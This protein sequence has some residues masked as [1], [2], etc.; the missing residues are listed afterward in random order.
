MKYEI[1]KSGKIGRELRSIA[2]DVIGRARDELDRGH[3]NGAAAIH[4]HRARTQFKKTRGVLRLA[5]PVLGK[6]EFRR[7]NA[8]FR[9]AG[10]EMRASRDSVALIESLDFLTKNALPRIS[11]A[12][13]RRLRGFLVADSR[14]LAKSLVSGDALARIADAIDKEREHVGE[15]DL[16]DLKGKDARRAWARARKQCREA[17]HIALADPSDENLHEWRK[18]TKTLL[19]Q[20]DLL[21]KRNPG[22]R[23]NRDQL[24]KLTEILGHDQDLA[25]LRKAI[26]DH[27]QVL[28]SVEG[29]KLLLTGVATRRRALRVDAFALAERI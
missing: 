9:D 6:E 12:I 19:F 3:E 13:I 14:K 4:V 1:P 10:R 8:A 24:K 20:T 21:R 25:M 7:G 16:S 15:W 18:R 22:T 17:F 5:R 27:K 2:L 28:R 11:P 26:L 29:V 23:E